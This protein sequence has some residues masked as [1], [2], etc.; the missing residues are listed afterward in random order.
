L[1]SVFQQHAQDL[2]ELGGLGGGERGEEILFGLLDHQSG[3]PDGGAAGVRQL[4]YVFASVI[5]ILAALDESLE[6]KV[7]RSRPAR[8]G[9]RRRWPGAPRPRGR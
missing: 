3:P 6:L 1:L 4:D 2:F 9:G 8:P 7:G 5:E